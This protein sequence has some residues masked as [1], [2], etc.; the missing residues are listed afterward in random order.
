[1][2]P[3]LMLMSFNFLFRGMQ[4]FLQG[5]IRAMGLQKIA[6]Y[7]AIGSFYILGIP[8]ACLLA[9]WKDYGVIGLEF[10]FGVALVMQA[11]CYAVILCRSDW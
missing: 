10:G 4:G 11:T 2:A 6:S 5:P 9:C 1:M 7:I 8:I 3:V